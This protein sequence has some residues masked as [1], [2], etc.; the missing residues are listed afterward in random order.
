VVRDP[1]RHDSISPKHRSA[2]T[3]LPSRT[4]ALTTTIPRRVAAAT[5]SQSYPL[6][7]ID[8]TFS[9]GGARARHPAGTIATP[10][11]APAPRRRRSV[12][13]RWSSDAG[14][15]RAVGDDLDVV[16]DRSQPRAALLKH[17]QTREVEHDD[18]RPLCTDCHDAKI[19]IL[20]E[21]AR[22]SLRL[23][24]LEQLRRRPEVIQMG[25]V[26]VVEVEV[27]RGLHL[28]VVAHDLD[29]AVA[30]SCARMITASS[31]HGVS[32]L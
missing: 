32:R 8:S 1:A 12:R 27:P 20:A 22:L 13:R 26:T 11:A 18:P 25:F 15:G 6:A 14:D 28:G 17:V 23:K 3:S 7:A 24:L 16:A 2:T 29:V 9:D 4:G 19:S 21:P 31:G 5:S 30:R 10:P